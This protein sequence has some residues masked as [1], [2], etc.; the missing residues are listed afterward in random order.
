MR[1]STDGSDPIVHNKESLSFLSGQKPPPDLLQQSTLAYR[2][3]QNHHKRNVMVFI[4]CVWR[5][6]RV[7]GRPIGRNA[8]F[9]WLLSLCAVFRVLCSSLSLSWPN[10]LHHINRRRFGGSVPPR[11][12]LPLHWLFR[13]CFQYL[14][15]VRAFP[16]LFRYGPLLEVEYSSRPVGL[17]GDVVPNIPLVRGTAVVLPNQSLWTWVALQTVSAFLGHW[18]YPPLLTRRCCTINDVQTM[19]EH[20]MRLETMR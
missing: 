17:A 15:L 16:M 10:R 2:F 19:M 20:N 13:S 9:Y 3:Y 7:I 6:L 4:K 8:S 14:N 5:S 1:I 18:S 12:A 11:S